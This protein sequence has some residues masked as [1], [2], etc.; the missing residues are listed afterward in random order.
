MEKKTFRWSVGSLVAALGALAIACGGQGEDDLSHQDSTV[1]VGAPAYLALGDSVPFGL[2]PLLVPPPNDNV[3]VGY[4]EYL[5]ELLDMPLENAACPGETTASFTSL[6]AAGAGTALNCAGFKASGWLHADY[7][8]TQLDYALEFLRTHTRVRLVTI[9]LGAND[10][11]DLQAACSF[12]AGCILGGLPSVQERIRSSMNQILGALQQTGYEG[13]IVVPL[14]YS[15]SPD[16]LVTG[17]VSAM[18]QA[19]A[20]IDPAL[21]VGFVD[22]QAAF[23]R[24]SA[25]FGNDPCAAGLLV[26]LP[27]GGCDEHPSVAGAQLIAAEIAQVVASR[28]FGGAT[29]PSGVNP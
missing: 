16:L 26:P 17:A 24:E 8:G 23:L 9:A 12:Q 6:E 20:G 27:G 13:E 5:R 25:A 29:T 11:F 22:L 2:N 15:P 4:P 19:L 1:G 7:T 18:N 10:L 14:Y 21:G 3:F 28:G